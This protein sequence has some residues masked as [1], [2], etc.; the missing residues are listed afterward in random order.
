MTAQS[1]AWICQPTGM[2]GVARTI[3][4]AMSSVQMTSAIQKRFKILGTS[5]QKLERST[6]FLVAPHW[7]LYEKRC[8]RR[9][10][11]R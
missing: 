11:E 1:Q 10:C 2:T 8:A 9:A 4:I 3:I 5:S 7:M 6:S